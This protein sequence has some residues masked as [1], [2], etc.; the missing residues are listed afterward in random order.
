MA[1]DSDLIRAGEA[2]R[3]LG[4]SRV[5]LYRW[6]TEGNIRHF[7]VGPHKER[8]FLRSDI[9][10]LLREREAKEEGGSGEE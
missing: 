9:L 8:R 2:A 3:I 7:E 5:T 6:A 10:A 1:P 4:V